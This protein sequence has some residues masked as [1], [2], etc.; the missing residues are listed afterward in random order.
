MANIPREIESQIIDAQVKMLQLEASARIRVS[1]LLTQIEKELVAR[2]SD[3]D[4]TKPVRTIYQRQRLGSLLADVKKLLASEYKSI[5]KDFEKE[6]KDIADFSA[7]LAANAVNAT[8]GVEIIKAA[9]TTE[10]LSILASD[11]LIEGAPSAEWWAKQASDVS[12]RFANEMRIGMAQGETIDDLIGRVRGKR[13]WGDRPAFTGIMDIARRNAE[14]LVRS[15]IITVSNAAHLTLYDNNTDVVRGLQWV[16]TLDSRTTPICRALDGKSWDMQKKP[17]GHDL[18]FPGVTAHWG[19]RSTQ[20][21]LLKDWNDL[22]SDPKVAAA[23]TAF[24]KGTRASIGGQLPDSTSYESWLQSRST[25]EQIDILGKGRYELWQAGKIGV[26][27]M[28]DQRGNPRTLKQ[29]KGL[30]DKFVK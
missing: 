15:S 2:L 6:L 5:G 26:T 8:L 9:L 12:S 27:D 30:G 24:D 7:G 3:K 1:D 22:I 4:P 25:A 13:A 23:L 10:Q 28:V 20:I 18:K 17:I 21:P 19:C 14:A 11:T 29:L 16:A